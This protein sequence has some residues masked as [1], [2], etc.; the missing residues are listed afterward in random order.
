MW[1]SDI[2]DHDILFFQSNNQLD[3]LPGDFKNVL[4][5]N[6]IFN[7]FSEINIWVVHDAI[8]R[9]FLFDDFFDFSDVSAFRVFTQSEG[10]AL[11]DL[12]PGERF[13][14]LFYDKWLGW[15]WCGTVISDGFGL[16]QLLF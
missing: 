15:G 16:E 10:L 7:D 8:K 4:P 9:V 2:S 13:I 14:E 12:L 5:V 3:H 6:I 1:W 11:K